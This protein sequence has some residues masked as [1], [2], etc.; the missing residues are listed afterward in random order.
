MFRVDLVMTTI[1]TLRN[2]FCSVIIVEIFF[3]CYCSEFIEG[4]NPFPSLINVN[5]TNED[6]DTEVQNSA[7]TQ[8]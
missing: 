1:W 3:Y 8:S 6:K 2:N 5:L 4:L 7:E